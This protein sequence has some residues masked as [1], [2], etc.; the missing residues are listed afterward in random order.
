MCRQD[1][2]LI[3]LLCTCYYRPAVAPAAVAVLVLLIIIVV[4]WLYS[5][6]HIIRVPLAVIGGLELVC[7]DVNVPPNMIFR[8]DM[9]CNN[10]INSNSNRHIAIFSI[11][12]PMHRY[13]YVAQR[14]VGM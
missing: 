3:T 2:R 13:N 1:C 5:I 14:V 6:N 7:G 11:R 8:S 12:Q 9:I 4:A 10:H